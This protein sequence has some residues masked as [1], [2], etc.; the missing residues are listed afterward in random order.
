MSEQELIR[1]LYDIAPVLGVLAFTIATLSGVVIF[2]YWKNDKLIEKMHGKDLKNLET[3][4]A[5][6]AVL[7]EVKFNGSEHTQQ[8]K[9]H[10]DDRINT[11]KEIIRNEGK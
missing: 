3:L 1:T 9:T 10:I 4:Q 11:L 2:L 8:L 5:L 7:K 6:S